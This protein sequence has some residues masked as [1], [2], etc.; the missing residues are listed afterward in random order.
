MKTEDKR[1]ATGTVD[2]W[3][4]IEHR[5][6]E[7]DRKSFSLVLEA[8]GLVSAC[9]GGGTVTAVVLG[10]G[11][12]EELGVL[13]AYGADRV[14]FA[15]DSSLDR[16]HGELFS[17]VL[18]RMVKK[19]QPSFL[20]MV[21]SAMTADLSPRLAAL[22]GTALVTRALDLDIDKD[23]KAVAIRPVANGYLF[24]KLIINTI[25]CSIICFLPSVLN[26]PP[27]CDSGRI[28]IITETT[29]IPFHELKTRLKDVI[30]V[31]SEVL[32][33]KDADI[34]V[35]GGRGAV[36]DQSFNIMHELAQVVGG[37]V[38]GTR[39]VIDSQL[40]PFDKQIGQTGQTVAPRLIFACGISGANEFTAGMEKSGLVI[41]INKDPNARIFRFSDLGL[42]GDVYELV[43]RLIEGLKKKRGQT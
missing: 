12:K 14:I 39:P 19:Y 1:A 13:G 7:L 4:F 43:P 41:G 37:S 21:Q 35:A 3:V 38:G 40:L 42:I 16:Y 30:T 2:V 32:D 18:F 27:A 10:S 26:E 6:G 22:L 24:E 29:D 31:D 33:I 5:D 23:G 36:R 8:R 11:L 17:A 9:N 15:E 28:E 34:I 25:L 20:L